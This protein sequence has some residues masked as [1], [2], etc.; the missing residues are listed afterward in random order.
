MSFAEIKKT[1]KWGIATW[2]FELRRNQEFYLGHFKTETSIIHPNED[3]AQ[4]R[5]VLEIH[6]K[7]LLAYR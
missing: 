6:I 5:A 2:K 7:I 1:S 3:R 4:G